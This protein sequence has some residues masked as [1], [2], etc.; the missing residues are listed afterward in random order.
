[1]FFV[2]LLNIGSTYEDK[3]INLLNKIKIPK[4]NYIHLK[5]FFDIWSCSNFVVSIFVFFLNT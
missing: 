2:R 4:L 1:M 3:N 5:H